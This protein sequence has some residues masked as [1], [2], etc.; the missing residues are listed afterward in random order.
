MRGEVDVRVDPAGQHG[1]AAQVDHGHHR[2]RSQCTDLAVGD[3]N[4][5]AVQHRPG[6]IF[7][8]NPGSIVFL[9]H[10][11]VSIF[12]VNFTHRHSCQNVFNHLLF[13]LIKRFGT[14]DNIIDSFF[15]IMTTPLISAKTISPGLT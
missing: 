10:L 12:S 3:A 11:F 7:A 13:P 4:A 5:G 14:L 8:L 9:Q 6:A 15:G 2:R 1:V